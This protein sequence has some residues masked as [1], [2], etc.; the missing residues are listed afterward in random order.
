M[1]SCGSKIAPLTQETCPPALLPHLSPINPPRAF[2][3]LCCIVIPKIAHFKGFFFNLH[4]LM[5][6]QDGSK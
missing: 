4:G 6:V 2:L 3:P 1:R 5:W